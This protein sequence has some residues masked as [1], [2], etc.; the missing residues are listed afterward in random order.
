MVTSNHSIFGNTN[1][2]IIIISNREFV[3]MYRKILVLSINLLP[4]SLLSKT[5]CLIILSA[6]FTVMTF[7]ARPFLLKQM[8]FLEFYSNLSALI[9]I[10]SGALYISDISDAFKAITFICILIVN[11]LFGILWITSFLQ[12]I[13]HVHINFF[14]K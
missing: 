11:I 6:I 3:I 12:I 8:N 2:I 5:V 14:L 13:F 10:Y 7:F 1:K 9:T 4:I